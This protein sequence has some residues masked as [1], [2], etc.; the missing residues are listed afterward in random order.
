M[1][2]IGKA[3]ATESCLIVAREQEHPI[4]SDTDYGVALGEIKMV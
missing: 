3:I 2:R 1:P 4:C